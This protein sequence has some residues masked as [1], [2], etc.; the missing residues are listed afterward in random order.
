[1]KK[2][3]LPEA[4]E[5]MK[6]YRANLHC[7]STISDG[8]KTP[9]QLKEDYK[10]NGYSIL[11][12]TDHDI[13]IPH[14]D[15]TDD[16]FLMLNG[17][18]LSIASDTERTCH[19]C[20]VATEKGNTEQVCYH[21]SNYI[22]GNAQ[23]YRSQINFDESKP[24]FERSY[25]PECVNEMIKTGV[26]SGFFVT[27][28]HPVWSVERYP[29]YMQFEGMDAMEIMNYASIVAGWDDDNGHC[30]DDMLYGGK[31]LFCIGADDNHNRV[32]DDDPKC[33][34]YG[35]YIMV[36]ASSLDYNTVGKALK[37][38]DFYAG[39]GD[40][41]RMG[42]EIY[43]LEYEDDIVRIKTSDARLISFMAD[44]RNNQCVNARVGENFVTEAE[45][46]VG[47]N[48]KWFRIVV[49]DD[50]GYKAYTNAYFT[51]ELRA[52]EK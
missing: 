26:D 48:V 35:G 12:I 27:Y 6:Y 8:G 44:V 13:L 41:K 5:N 49:T 14:D 40:Y 30:Y 43:S 33:G 39:Y 42:P 9:E 37:N 31:R 45:F 10:K 2:I 29:D 51:D 28:N 50:L 32:P 4:G 3:L 36:A 25:T 19:L 18:E 20:L 15:L 1:M 24:D 16:D 47:Q 23:N 46:K 7:H 21:R 34:S 17:Y 22:W 11:S 52:E 38:G